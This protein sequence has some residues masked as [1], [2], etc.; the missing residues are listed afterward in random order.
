MHDWSDE[1]TLI[2][3]L[4][5]LEVSLVKAFGWSLKDI[6]ETDVESLIAFLGRMTGQS[7]GSQRKAFCDE[8]SFL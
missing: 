4:I 1:R 2:E 6:D 8:V 7:A 3:V 5:D